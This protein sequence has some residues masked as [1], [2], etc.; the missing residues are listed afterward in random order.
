M[1]H[2]AQFLSKMCRS[3]SSDLDRTVNFSAS[4]TDATIF[5]LTIEK[6]L[7]EP[8]FALSVFLLCSLETLIKCDLARK[9]VLKADLI[10]CLFK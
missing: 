8:F 6:C 1:V 7:L 2:K 10:L 3:N 5:P 9:I 4:V